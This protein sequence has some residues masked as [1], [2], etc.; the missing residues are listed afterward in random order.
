MARACLALYFLFM[1]SEPHSKL[2]H[3]IVGLGLAAAGCGGQATQSVDAE[4]D[5]AQSIPMEAA[6]SP[7][8]SGADAEPDARAS[9]V[10]DATAE[11]DATTAADVAADVAQ[12]AWHPVPIV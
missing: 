8:A 1:R 10:S 4:A 12:E 5:A 9:P 7:D 6:L 2:F 11:F 3:A